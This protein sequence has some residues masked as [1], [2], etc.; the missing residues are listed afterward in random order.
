MKI[1]RREFT[2]WRERDWRCERWI[3]NGRPE[4]RLYFGSH[5]MSELSDGP[6]VSLQQQTDEWLAAV[7]ADC[8]RT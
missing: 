5:Q 2:L 7:R 3:V 8:H 1:E 4:V 6:H